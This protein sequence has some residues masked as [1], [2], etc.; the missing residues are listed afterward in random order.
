M[1]VSTKDLEQVLAVADKALAMHSEWREGLV[2]ILLCKLPLPDSAV[3][4]D[5]HQHCA[6]GTWF[7]SKA[8]AHLRALPAFQRIG[9]LH[10]RM[11]DSARDMCMRVKASG[12]AQ[13]D[14]Y[15]RFVRCNVEFHG[16]L[17]QFRHRVS[18]TLQNAGS[19][20]APGAGQPG[21]E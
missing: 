15:D 6:F 7:Y 8:N 14:D 1:N 4:L 9:E 18:L 10:E 17:E 13:E 20:E 12:F 5:A 21:S 16:A 19:P 11:H 3:A 2:R